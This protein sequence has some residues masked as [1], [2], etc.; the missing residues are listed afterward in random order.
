MRPPDEMFDLSKDYILSNSLL[1]QGAFSDGIGVYF[2]IKD[3]E[4]VYIGKSVGLR[5]RLNR[6]RRHFD[7]NRV[8]IIPHTGNDWLID[9]EYVYIKKFRPRLNQSSNPDLRKKR[10]PSESQNKKFSYKFFGLE[11]KL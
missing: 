5:S 1:V 10:V 8:F 3:D 9:L 4:I 2:L 6:H 11:I 7:F